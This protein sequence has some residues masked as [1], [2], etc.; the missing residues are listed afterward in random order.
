MPNLD[1]GEPTWPSL[2]G[3]IYIGEEKSPVLAGMK[4]GQPVWIGILTQF[5]LVPHTGPQQNQ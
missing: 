3:E 4:A 2:P 1:L 5:H